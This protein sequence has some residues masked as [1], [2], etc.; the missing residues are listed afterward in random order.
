VN[1]QFNGETVQALAHARQVTKSEALRALRLFEG[2]VDKADAWL[3]LTP[4]ERSNVFEETMVRMARQLG[5]WS[6][7]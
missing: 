1:K 2:D 5:F 7:P 4:T 3:K 6:F